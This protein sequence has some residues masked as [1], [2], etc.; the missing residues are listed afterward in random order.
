M[1]PANQN[2]Q[3]PGRGATL[4]PPGAELL[5][6]DEQLRVMSSFR[7]TVKLMV[8]VGLVVTVMGAMVFVLVD[9]IFDTLTPSMRHDLEW[10]ALHGVYELSGRVELGVAANDPGSIAAA[11]SE[12]ASDPDVVA[13]RVMNEKGPLYDYGKAPKGWSDGLVSSKVVERGELLIATDKVDIEDLSIGRVAL[14]VSKRRL[15]AGIELRRSVLLAAALGGGLALLLALGFVQYD[16]GPLIR[17]TAEAFRKLE[18]TT[19][20][21]LESARIKSEFLANMSHEIRTPMNGIMGVTRLALGMAMDAKLRRY[22]EVIDTS[23]RGLLTIINDVL[24][25]SKM[26]SGK[27][28]I[29]PR[30]F[31][32]RE[33]VAES[34]AIFAQRAQERGLVVD[35]HVA[36]EVP[37]EVVGDPDR[38]KQILVNLVGNAVKFTEVGEVVVEAKLT[39]TRDRLLLQFDVRDT[40]CGIREEARAG[41]FHAFTQ[42]DGS[43][44]RQHGGTGLGLAIAKRLAQLMG[45]DVWL[46]SEVGHGSEFSF[47]VEILRT[48]MRGTTSLPPSQSAR[49][50]AAPAQR[51]N[52]PL[53]VVDDNE[54]NRFVAVEHLTRMGYRAVTVTG[55]ED[56][57]NAVFSGQY[58]AVLMDCQMP[59]MDGYSATREIRRR[60]HGSTRHIPIIAVTAHALD[61]EKAHV[62]AAGMDDYI[63]KPFT[64]ALLE[65]TLARWIGRPNTPTPY[66]PP[67]AAPPARIVSPD[68]DPNLECSPKLIDLFLRLAPSQLEE[69]RGRVAARDIESARAHAHK[70]KGGLYAVGAHELASAIEEQRAQM[71]A[72]DW[73]R[74]DAKLV[75]IERRFVNVMQALQTQAPANET[76]GAASGES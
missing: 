28:E 43:A 50:S 76:R 16:I 33:L 47:S 11:A 68:L 49:G 73:D 12:L 4:V 34:I 64:P 14:A 2:Q 67:S 38:I 9:Q 53:L 75:E 58:A 74:V 10:K 7:L 19:Q 60:E 32:P 70:L 71:A 65:R 62:I 52:R 31:S 63:A 69:L 8:M 5:T 51:T 45:G 25:F 23:S 46:K 37:Q 24:D 61:G 59:G 18:R 36:P 54:I 66:Q 72:G 15:E 30:E 55:G 42:V 22:L 26:E 20:A 40:G 13:I 48:K 27:Y 41:L 57:V 17:L 3:S 44:A 1:N 29:R 39:G 6:S 35:H 56:A 21:A